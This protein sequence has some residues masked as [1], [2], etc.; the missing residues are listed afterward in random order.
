[1][2]MRHAAATFITVAF[3][4][5]TS[6]L[7]TRAEPLPAAPAALA[8]QVQQT[9]QVVTGLFATTVQL[10]VYGSCLVLGGEHELCIEN[11]DKAGRR[12]AGRSG[13]DA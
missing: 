8:S 3:L 5:L 11:A 1:M 6:A 13:D 12:A 7:P 2:T 9:A 4:V 10:S